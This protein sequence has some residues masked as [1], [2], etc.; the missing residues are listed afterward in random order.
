[1]TNQPNYSNIASSGY[2]FATFAWKLNPTT[3]NYSNISFKIFGCTED[4]MSNN[5]VIMYYR[6]QDETPGYV[7]ANTNG[8]SVWVDAKAVSTISKANYF[9]NDTTST[10]TNTILGGQPPTPVYNFTSNRLTI[11]CNAPSLGMTASPHAGVYLYFR[12]GIAMT[13]TIGFS[14]VTAAI[15]SIP[16]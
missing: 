14:Y 1:M 5:N 8:N 10:T 12:I 13:T 4:L 2:R 11:Y 7:W 9:V 6:F 3:A 15:S 16:I